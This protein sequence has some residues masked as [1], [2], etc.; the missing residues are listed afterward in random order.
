MDTDFLVFNGIDGVTGD[1]LLPPMP[2][3]EL[4]RMAQGQPI[5]PQHLNE[6][7]WKYRQST[8][9]HYGV[10]EGVD[11][12]DLAQAGW[13]VI[14]AYNA[15]PAVRQALSELLSHRQKQAAL[16]KE[17]RYKEYSGADGYRPGETKQA[18]LARHGVGPGPVNPDRV[19]YYLL[20]VGDPE[21]IPYRFQYQLDV[22]YAV[23]RVHFDTLAEYARYAHSVVAA[24]T[25]ESAIPSQRRAVFFATENADDKATAMSANRLVKPL[26]EMLQVDQP[27]WQVESIVGSGATKAKLSTLLGA[28]GAPAL[29]FTASHG[30]AFPNGD[31]RQV[32][33]Q[34]AL[35]CQDWPGPEAWQ[36]GVPPGFY[37][38]GDD[39]GDDARLQGMIA[40]TFACYGLG[41]PRL[42][43]FPQ[44][45]ER[46][47]IAQQAF[48]AHLPQ[49]LL[50]HPK[51]G[52]LAVIGHM[53]RAWSYSFV[54]PGAGAQNAVFES[55]FKRLMEGCPVGYATEFFN[56]RYAELS[57][58]LSTELEEVKFGGLRDDLAL[59]G[60]WI[61]NNDARNYGILGD[62]AVRLQP[63]LP[64]CGPVEV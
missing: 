34:G 61:A 10:V 17:N 47:A 12:K 62:P 9:G 19:P 40:V 41:T 58:D 36:K 13:G 32:R 3:A 5:D 60:M 29:L 64:K 14:F 8:E 55:M 53:E 37:F 28:D 11:P 23:G 52:A 15:E 43:D 38:A 54:W 27:A 39:V 4:S 63:A 35:L 57:S 20:I 45:G 24:E 48:V 26:A 50:G 49:R 6:L 25:A 16:Q 59:A 42:D 18:F 22:Q 51:G 33:G 44:T 30:M 21:A 46:Q 56:E 7:R 1:Y 2:P 31:S